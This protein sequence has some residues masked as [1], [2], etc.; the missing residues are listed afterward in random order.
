M[1]YSEVVPVETKVHVGE[2]RYSYTI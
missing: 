1:M 2:W